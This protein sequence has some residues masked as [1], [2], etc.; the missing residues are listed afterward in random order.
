MA[1]KEELA[2][3]ADRSNWE[4]LGTEQYETAPDVFEERVRAFNRAT[5]EAFFGVPADFNAIFDV[6]VPA[7]DRLRVHYDAAGAPEF[8]KDAAGNV[9]FTY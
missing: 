6:P 5:K 3:R 4:V 8:V 7:D 2:A 1:T 9:V